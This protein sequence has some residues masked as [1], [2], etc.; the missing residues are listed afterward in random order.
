VQQPK[1]AAMKL[2][3]LIM[4]ALLAGCATASNEERASLLAQPINC[5]TAQED[6]VALEAAMPSRGERAGAALRTVTP[7]GA[8]AGAATGSYRDGAAVLTGRTEE[9]LAAR[10]SEIQATCGIVATT[11]NADQ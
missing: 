10:I 6:I 5:E 8:V 9:E 11:D 2:A 1:E 7:V 4:I 3:P